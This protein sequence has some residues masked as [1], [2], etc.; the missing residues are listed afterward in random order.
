MRPGLTG[1]W[2]VSGRNELGYEDR[3][4]LEERYVHR[5][6]LALDI[7]ILLRTVPRVIRGRGAY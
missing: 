7:S 3:V 5:W 1:L 6:T 4:R 2:G